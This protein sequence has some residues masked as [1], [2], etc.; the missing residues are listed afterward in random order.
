MP[1][2]SLPLAVVNADTATFDCSFGRGCEGICCKNGRPSV[3]PDEIARIEDNLPKFLPHLRPS[4]RKLVE[5]EGFLSKRVKLGR[6]MLRVTE[7]WCVFFNKG[8]VLH[9]VGAQDGDSFQ[10]KPVQCALFPLELDV[11]RGEWYIRQWEYRNEDWDLFCLNPKNSSR[12]ASE[13]LADEIALAAA[14][15]ADS[16]FLPSKPGKK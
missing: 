13:S 16:V 4:A 11:T 9:K 12:K 8:C 3:G 10:Y 14:G 7:S 1:K 6:P 2:K 5:A 15:A